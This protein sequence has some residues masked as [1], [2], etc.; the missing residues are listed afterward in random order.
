MAVVHMGGGAEEALLA[1]LALEVPAGRSAWAWRGIR[2]RVAAGNPAAAHRTSISARFVSS[3]PAPKRPG[4]L[5]LLDG[6]E[7]GAEISLAE[8]SSPL[9]WMISKKMGPI[10]VWVKICSTARP[11]PRPAANHW[12]P[13][14]HILAMV[15]QTR[16]QIGVVSGG[17]GA[18]KRTPCAAGPSTVA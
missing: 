10:T 12:R 2:R 15:R 1:Q 5:I 11:A 17:Q 4:D 18:M 6:F 9:R 13:A 14:R 16:R 8:S 3:R 7:Q